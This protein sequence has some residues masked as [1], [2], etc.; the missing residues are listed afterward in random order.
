MNEIII[1]QEVQDAIDLLSVPNKDDQRKKRLIDEIKKAFGPNCIKEE[2]RDF[3]R[4][5][6]I[7]FQNEGN[8]IIIDYH[9]AGKEFGKEGIG[10]LGTDV[11]FIDKATAYIEN[12]S[13]RRI[14]YY[15][16]LNLILSE[17]EEM[18][19][20]IPIFFIKNN[21]QDI[22]KSEYKGSIPP[23]YKFHTINK[24]G[25][26]WLRLKNNRYEDL[27]IFQTSIKGLLNLNLMNRYDE[28]KEKYFNTKKDKEELLKKLVK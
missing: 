12:N 15:V 21:K 13:S 19:F 16:L 28:E 3:K 18:Y 9:F 24:K 1:S 20:A 22:S 4:K 2:T 5:H 7:V 11:N 26:Y 17:E 10:F 25:K 27:S 23:G 8:E 14:Y 6:I